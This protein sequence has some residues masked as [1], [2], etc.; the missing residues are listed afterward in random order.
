MQRWIPR[1][2][3]DARRRRQR[4]RQRP[5]LSL[6]T[7]VRRGAGASFLIKVV[8]TGLS[9][10]TGILLARA[11]GPRDYGIY[12]YAMAAVTL[13]GV[14]AALGFPMLV[15]RQVAAY[16]GQRQWDL[17]R[18]LLRRTNQ[19]IALSSLGLAALA[20]GIAWLLAPNLPDGGLSTFVAA[21]T[22]VPLLAFAAQR[23]AA[24]QGL[25]HVVLAQIPESLLRPGLFLAGAAVLYLAMGERF[26]PF[27][28]M[29]MHV[30]A[31]AVAF[32]VGAHM[33]MRHR[34]AAI[35]RAVPSY[36]TGP[37]L[38]SAV[39][40][41]LVAGAHMANIHVDLLML[42]LFASSQDV[43]IYR[44]A[45]RGAEAILFVL[46]AANLTAAP[47]F[48]QLYHNDRHGELQRIVTLTARMVLSFALPA[49]LVLI[50]WGEP[51]L[52]FLFG[53]AYTGAALALAILAAGQL[54][55]AG[56][57]S[58]GTLLNMTG[59]ERVSARA[60]GIAIAINIGLNASLIPLWGIDGAA[61]ATATST[62]LW[63]V[64]MAHSVFR[65]LNINATAFA[66]GPHWRTG[67]A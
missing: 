42:G 10:L 31:T 19:L 5:R 64:L 56:L 59:H 53:T 57:G 45:S 25:R 12:A 24:L 33:L 21:A 58:V 27:P 63:N 40:M 60:A 36:R 61:V 34:P 17:L 37:W 14:P 4:Q 49:A 52:Q 1:S 29:I 3:I 44:V 66:G 23:V 54:V 11:L 15:V 8:S 26:G 13:L 30:A 50:V 47:L 62:A 32:L 16:H 38:T 43:G 7:F 2:N 6:D 18:G 48:S 41:M 9:F 46:M 55:N 28:A 35:K 20:A 65:L 39:P 67:Q 22:M 51:I